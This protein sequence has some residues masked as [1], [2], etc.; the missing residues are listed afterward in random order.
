MMIHSA[1]LVLG[2]GQAEWCDLASPSGPRSS[3]HL[4]R[5]GRGRVRSPLWPS[6]LG[7]SPPRRPGESSEP[8]LV[9]PS[10]LWTGEVGRACEVGGGNRD[11]PLSLR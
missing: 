10:A 9:P 4:P 8:P 7:P 6:F 3:A 11:D 1:W 5:E 2:A